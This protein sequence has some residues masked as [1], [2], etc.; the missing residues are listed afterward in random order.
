MST[1]NTTKK[2]KKEKPVL[3]LTTDTQIEL[4]SS[5]K[6]LPIKAKDIDPNQSVIVRNGF[7]G[8]LIYK[9]PRTGE[10]FIWPEFGDEQ[11]MDLKELRNAKNSYKKAFANN[12]F[13]FD[14]DWVI[15][16]LGVRNHYKNA[17]KIEEFDDLFKKPAAEIT[18][19]ISK[20]SDGQKKSVGYRARQ[21]IADGEID[22][23]K[24]ISA[25]EDALG[26]EL[27]EK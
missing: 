25:I 5:E 23:R 9:S 17:L 27:I 3:D 12:W 26:I 11:E 1:E 21:L 22:S 6:A 2:P 20:L 15:D 10:R 13:M 14:E 7:Q 16:Y 18:K 19:V 8:R 24:A 4:E